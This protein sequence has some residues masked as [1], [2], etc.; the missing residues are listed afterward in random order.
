MAIQIIVSKELERHN[1]IWLN[2]LTDNLELA[3]DEVNRLIG[4]I[5][6]TA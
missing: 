5:N 6:E 1:H 2:S 4:V 3:V